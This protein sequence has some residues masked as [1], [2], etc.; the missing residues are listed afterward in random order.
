MKITAILLCLIVFGCSRHEVPITPI[1]SPLAGLWT[2]R[3]TTWYH[4]DDDT[5]FRGDTMRLN[6]N[7]TGDSCTYIVL[8][9]ERLRFKN[10]QQDPVIN[11]TFPVAYSG[12]S[13]TIMSGY[14]RLFHTGDTLRGL[15][16]DKG[17]GFPL[18]FTR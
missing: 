6:F 11:G 1:K 7:R 15:Y 4:A 10:G 16:R 5:N 2:Q 17:D 9:P 12:D 8:D 14:F 13:L 18:L 3:D